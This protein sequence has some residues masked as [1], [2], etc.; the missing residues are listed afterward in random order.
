MAQQ[1]ALIG[2]EHT[3]SFRRGYDLCAG[4]GMNSVGDK[5]TTGIYNLPPSVVNHK[6]LIVMSRVEEVV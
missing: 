3:T 6:P 4:H 2:R 1:N 5:P